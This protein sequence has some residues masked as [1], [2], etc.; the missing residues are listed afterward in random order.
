MDRAPHIAFKSTFL[1]DSELIFPALEAL[2]ILDGARI[3]AQVS[4]ILAIENTFDQALATA[5][6]WILQA[7]DIE[8]QAFGLMGASEQAKLIPFEL[9][10]H[11]PHDPHPLA[12]PEFG[13]CD[14]FNDG[15]FV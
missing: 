9:E 6:S 14:E 8:P 3:L 12:I 11:E 1:G 13:V 5:E 7:F 10:I 4:P 2:E 15:D